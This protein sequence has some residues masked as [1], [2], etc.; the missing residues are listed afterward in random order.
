[1]F[2][3]SASGAA[4]AGGSSILGSIGSY[5]SGFFADGGYT[6]AGAKYDEAGI[7]HKGEYVIPAWQV[8][9]MPNTIQALESV[10]KKGYADGGYVGGLPNSSDIKVEIINESGSKLEITNSQ[11]NMDMG[12]LLIQAWVKDYNSGGITRQ[13]LG[14]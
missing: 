4:S 8:N 10:R 11:A 2:S 1:M 3:S 5:I 14:K 6:G 7:V 12:K 13:T 9:K